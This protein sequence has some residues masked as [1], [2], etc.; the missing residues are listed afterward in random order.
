V[1][2]SADSKPNAVLIVSND[3]TSVCAVSM[4]ATVVVT[5]WLESWMQFKNLVEVA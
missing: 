4:S 5:G 3:G 2:K 1:E